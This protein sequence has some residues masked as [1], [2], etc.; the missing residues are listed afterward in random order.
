MEDHLDHVTNRVL[1]DAGIREALEK[2]WSASAFMG[3]ATTEEKLR[4][5]AEALDCADA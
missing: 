5:T 3:T 2:L 4:A 1:P